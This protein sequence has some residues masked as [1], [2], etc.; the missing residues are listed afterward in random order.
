MH[1]VYYNG[2]YTIS[3]RPI[4]L[5][6]WIADFDFNKEFP[7][8][9]P[10]WVKFPNLPMSCW[11]SRTLSRIASMLGNPVFADE[12]TTKQTRISYARMLVEINVSQPLSDE[13]TVIDPKGKHFQQQVTYDWK[14]E[15]CE[16]SQV[17]GHKCR[18]KGEEE[19][20]RNMQH[21]RRRTRTVTQ[22]WRTKGPIQQNAP[23]EK[24]KEQPKEV[25]QQTQQISIAGSE[26][27]L[28]EQVRKNKGKAL[29]SPEFNL[30][31]FPMLC[32][33]PV[34][35]GFGVLQGGDSVV[36]TTPLDKGGGTKTI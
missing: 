7:T 8:E 22:E 23:V 24:Q 3:N 25:T 32:S 36:Q 10:L 15:F 33:V 6:P 29:Q 17:V 19:E 13:I 34:K 20:Q 1:T 12:C 18:E 21:R 14:P 16:T 35:N 5:K 11:G 9:I 26:E 2:P 31:N 28:E 27:G 4:I 30:Q